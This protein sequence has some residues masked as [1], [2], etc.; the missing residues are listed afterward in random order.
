MAYIDW[1]ESFSVGIKIIDSQHKML[2][3]LLNQLNDVLEK[4]ED[5]TLTTTEV[6]I[7]GLLAYVDFHFT[8][9]EK[10]FEEFNYENKEAHIQ[11]HHF[12]IKKINEF[13]DRY[14]KEGD[15]II[16]EV[17]IFLKDWILNHINI[18]D[19][20]YTKCFHEHGLP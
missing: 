18:S 9:E 6:A 13:H 20:K 7:H 15:K 2:F 14:P 19:K 10:Y 17:L 8:T 3:K 16:N 1:N 12:Y 5:E 4:P 11:Q